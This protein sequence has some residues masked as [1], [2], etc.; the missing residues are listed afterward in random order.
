MQGRIVID[1][2]YLPARLPLWQTLIAILALDH[3]HAPGWM[4]GSVL[5]VV[6]LFWIVGVIDVAKQ[7]R[8]NLKGDCFEQHS[9]DG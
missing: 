3:W 6:A 1:Y 8:F 7:K 4:W 2:K 9:F 5:A